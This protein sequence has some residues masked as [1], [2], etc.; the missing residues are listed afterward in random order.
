MTTATGAALSN[1]GLTILSEDE[2]LFRDYLNMRL[3]PDELTPE[4]EERCR[5]GR[6]QIARGEFV[7]LEE[8][9]AELG[10]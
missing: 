7:T 9:E 2:E 4:E 1:A 3:D 10:L 5:E 6:E 8:L